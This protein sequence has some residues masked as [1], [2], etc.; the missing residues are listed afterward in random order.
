MKYKDKKG[1]KLI[2]TNKVVTK[3]SPQLKDIAKN[4]I[5]N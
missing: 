1:E 4:Y 2:K 5:V 3:M